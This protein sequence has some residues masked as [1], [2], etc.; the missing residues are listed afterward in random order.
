MHMEKENDS[1][2]KVVHDKLHDKLPGNI[3]DLVPLLQKT[4]KMRRQSHQLQQEAAKAEAEA[5]L[6][7]NRQRLE[8]AGD[9]IRS[10]RKVLEEDCQRVSDLEMEQQI[11]LEEN[12]AAK[13][14]LQDA[15]QEQDAYSSDDE[16]NILFETVRNAIETLHAHQKQ[17]LQSRKRRRSEWSQGSAPPLE[18]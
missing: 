17:K 8:I 1:M 7:A 9:K 5:E 11:L 16:G 12:E 4:A 13:S 15:E 14:R 18:K 6:H 10:A 2:A 3:G